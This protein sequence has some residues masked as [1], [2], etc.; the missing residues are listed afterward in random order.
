MHVYSEYVNTQHTWFYNTPSCFWRF[1]EL[2]PRW[3]SLVCW[4]WQDRGWWHLASTETENVIIINNDT[5]INPGG[6]GQKSVCPDRLMILDSAVCRLIV[7]WTSTILILYLSKRAWWL[8][9]RYFW[10]KESLE[11]ES[12]GEQISHSSQ[13]RGDGLGDYNVSPTPTWRFPVDGLCLDNYL[14]WIFSG[15]MFISP[16]LQS[17]LSF[18]DILDSFHFSL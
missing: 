5:K 16:L 17:M 10:T 1:P 6:S 15:L 2:Q 14:T 18:T 7:L 12:W 13:R 8:L 3:E 4:T 9:R 11:C